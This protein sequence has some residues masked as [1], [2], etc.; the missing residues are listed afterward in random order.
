MYYISLVSLI[1]LIASGQQME[2]LIPL[3]YIHLIEVPEM[4][5]FPTPVHS[6]HIRSCRVETGPLISLTHLTHAGRWVSRTGDIWK[7]S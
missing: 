1:N 6:I 7:N 4:Q 3:V 5:G 2:Q